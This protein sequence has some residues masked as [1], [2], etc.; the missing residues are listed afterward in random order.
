VEQIPRYAPRG[1]CS[2]Y[3]PLR[4]SLCLRQRQ[5]RTQSMGES[6][7]FIILNLDCC[8]GSWYFKYSGFG[9]YYIKCILNI[10]VIW[11]YCILSFLFTVYYCF[12][13][14]WSCTQHSSLYCCSVEYNTRLVM[15]NIVSDLLSL[16]VTLYGTVSDPATLLVIDTFLFPAK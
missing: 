10:S 6:N 9:N 16:L 13:T 15:F 2:A 8:R 1:P 5:R 7:C 3:V 4:L 11:D 14:D 12:L